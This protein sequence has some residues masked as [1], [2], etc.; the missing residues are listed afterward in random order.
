MNIRSTSA[1]TIPTPLE[2][3]YHWESNTPD[4]N[5]LRQPKNGQEERYTWAEFGRA[6]RCAAQA[7]IDKDLP[8][9]SNICLLSKNCAEWFIADLAIMMAGHVS[10]PIF[11]TAGHDTIKYIL[12]HAEIKLLFL[13]KLDKP[14]ETVAC[15]PE[16]LD[17]V[18]FPY[19]SAHVG[20]AWQAFCNVSPYSESPI[21]DLDDVMTI[22][23]TSGSTGTPKGVVHSYYTINFAANFASREL[24]WTHVDRVMSYLPLAHITERV[25]IELASLQAGLEVAF[26]ESLDTFVHDVQKMQPTFY[27]AVP[28][29]WTKFQMNILQ[30]MP[31]KKLDIL[32]AIPFVSSLVK[33]KIKAGLGA[34]AVHTFASGSAP[35]PAPI[36]KWFKK[37]GIEITEAWGMSETSAYG[38]GNFPFREDKIGTIGRPWD[39]VD[40]RLSDECEILIKTPANMLGY[41]KD[42]EK[43]AESF[44]SEGYFKTGDRGLID[45][46]GYVTI[47]GRVKE[48]FKTSKGKYVVPAPIEAQFTENTLIEQICVTGSELPQPIALVVLSEDGQKTPEHELQASLAATLQKV[49]ANLES[50]MRL[51]HLV[52]LK[53]EWNVDNNLLTPTLKIKRHEIEKQFAKQIKQNYQEKVVINN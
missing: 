36:M 18:S 19:E 32:L 16:H 21:P 35:L 47:T 45:A 46:D 39:R 14:A 44:D 38:T 22:I 10:V 28:R 43:T 24:G 52:V 12:Q 50:H 26:V 23:Y 8:P 40:I 29:L 53:E 7:I 13:G 25:V 11:P 15:L 37:I 5:Y 17:I 20:Q 6:V 31:Q 2:R 42:E 30:K 3:L 1:A 9:K 49:N 48:I 33:K 34:S 27:L 51:A 41:Y 4:V